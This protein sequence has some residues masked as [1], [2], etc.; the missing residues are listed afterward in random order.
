LIQLDPRTKLITVFLISSVSI[1]TKDVEILS[2]LL[3]IT[4]FICKMLSVS[5][6]KAMKRLKNLLIFFL[7]LA[8]VQSI[9]TSGNE[10]IFS[11]GALKILTIEGLLSGISI[12]IR[13]AIIISSALIIT[14]SSTMEIIY[15]LIAMKLPYE[16]AFMVLISIKFLP[17]FKEEFVDSLTAIQLSGVD[18][19]EIPL[20]QKLSLYSY[21]MTPSTIKALKRAK[22]ISISMECRGFRS[23]DT[24]TSYCKLYM[25]KTDYIFLIT[26]LVIILLILFLHY[27]S[28]IG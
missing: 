17:I 21:I 22:Y 18:I 26:S 10:V 7:A 9:F 2:I 20:K 27:R 12:V 8:L 19:Y 4:I 5:F 25:T 1:I 11:I 13:M 16:I 28:I 14:T 15:G 3:L 23:K 6:L 24:R